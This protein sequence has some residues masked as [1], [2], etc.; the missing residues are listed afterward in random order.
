MGYDQRWEREEKQGH[1]QWLYKQLFQT[2]AV[3][4]LKLGRCSVIQEQFSVALLVCLWKVAILAQS[5]ELNSG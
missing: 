2:N 3:P 1:G 5:S 4:V